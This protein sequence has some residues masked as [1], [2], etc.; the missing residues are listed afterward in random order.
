MAKENEKYLIKVIKEMGSSYR[1]RSTC[2]VTSNSNFFR[3][4]LN[5]SRAIPK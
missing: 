3:S 5:W 4:S 1:V 2:S